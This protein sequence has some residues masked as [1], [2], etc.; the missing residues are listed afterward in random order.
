MEVVTICGHQVSLTVLDNITFAVQ[1]V[2]LVGTGIVVGIFG[3]LSAL[4]TMEASNARQLTLRALIDAGA[5]EEQVDLFRAKFGDSVVVTEDLCRSVAGEFDWDWFAR[6]L[7]SQPMR[8]QYA[9]ARK[10]MLDQYQVACAV[11]F[12]DLYNRDGAND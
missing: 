6:N 1:C 7:L 4:R 10:P 11:I 12:A 3:T 9:A 8:D 5:C 2:V